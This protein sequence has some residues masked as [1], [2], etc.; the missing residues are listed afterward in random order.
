[1]ATEI[2]DPLTYPAGTDDLI[3]AIAT[4]GLETVRVTADD[5]W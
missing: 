2:D 5:L 3:V 4:L 1:M